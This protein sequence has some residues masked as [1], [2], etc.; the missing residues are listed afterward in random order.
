M[1][2]V[3]E[4]DTSIWRK[5]CSG[6]TRRHVKTPKL[7]IIRKTGASVKLSAIYPPRVS[8]KRLCPIN[9]S[10]KVVDLVLYPNLRYKFIWPCFHRTGTFFS[11]TPNIQC[12]KKRVTRLRHVCFGTPNAAATSKQIFFHYKS[13]FSCIRQPLTSK[14]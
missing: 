12:P 2:L 5:N 8:Q 13:F 4:A 6:A 11:G 10:S 3:P 14:S 9:N 7:G 1:T